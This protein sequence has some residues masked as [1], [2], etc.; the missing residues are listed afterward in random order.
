MTTTHS[1]ELNNGIWTSWLPVTTA[2]TSQAACNSA[3]WA[4]VGIDP[5]DDFW[6]YIYDPA[7]AQSVANSLT[8]LPPEATQWWEGASTVSSTITSW[9]LGPLICPSAYATVS[10]IIVSETST[11]VICCP[12]CV[13]C[14]YQFADPHF[15]NFTNRYPHAGVSTS[16][17]IFPRTVALMAYA[18]RP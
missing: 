16:C 11:S 7:F 12:T 3:A 13:F 5:A 2:W 18:Y 8:C 15:W 6:P 14:I 1:P 4:R 10:V 17:A 9:S